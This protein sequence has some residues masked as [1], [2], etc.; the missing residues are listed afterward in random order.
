MR[1][2]DRCVVAALA[3]VACASPAAAHHSRSALYDPAKR[4]DLTGTVTTLDWRNPHVHVS[5]DVRDDRGRVTAWVCEA[6]APNAL[7]R[8]GWHADSIE[9]GDR[10]ELEGDRARDGSAS[11]TIRNIVL[12]GAKI[13]ASD[14]PS[15][16]S[17]GPPRKTP[18]G[19]P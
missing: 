11:C 16:D 15:L 17:A 13:F 8:R 9:I 1:V 3:A 4:V 18:P 12:N 5:F 2:T 6:A 14:S 7:I 10:I 19:E